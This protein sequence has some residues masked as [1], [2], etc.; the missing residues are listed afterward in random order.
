MDISAYANKLDPKIKI[1]E[2]INVSNVLGTINPVVEVYAMARTIG[3]FCLVDGAQSLPHFKVDVQSLG[4]DFFTFSV[5][6]IFAPTCIGAP[7]RQI[8]LLDSM[9]PWQG[10]V[11]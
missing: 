10:A 11:A 7:Y 9:S 6:K 5:H 4:Y 1:I 8:D 2:I 3:E